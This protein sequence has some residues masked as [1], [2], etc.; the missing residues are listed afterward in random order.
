VRKTIAYDLTRTFVG[1]VFATPRGVD[2]VDF[3]FARHLSQEPQRP[4]IGVLPTPWGMRV[5][6]ADRVERGLERLEDLWAETIDPADDVAYQ[7]LLGSLASR[8]SA[9]PSTPREA[10]GFIQK[11]RRM[12]SLIASTGFSFGRS[13]IA[14][15]PRN[16]V[17]FNVGQYTTAIPQLLSWLDR[18]RD[19]KPVFMLHDVIPLEKPECVSP[20]EL[21]F[22]KIMVRS[23]ARY[24]AGLIVTT[25]HA[26]KTILKA[27]ADEGRSGI[28]TLSISLPL[29]DAF[30]SAAKP[31][32]LLED[33]PYFVVCG[34]VEPRKNHQLLVDVW[35][36]LCQS[37]ESA[38]HL[39]VIGSPG[40]GGQPILDRMFG[41]GPT[42]GKIHH[43]AGLSTPAM[44]SL[45]AGS[46]GLLSPSLTEGFGLPIIEA[47]HLGAPVVAS[48]IPAHR[49]VAGDRATLVDP[50]D[51]AAWR[52]AVI[53]LSSGHGR[54]ASRPAAEASRER[55]ACLDE[56]SEFLQSF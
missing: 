19:V 31:E 34:A 12:A 27:L 32:P 4:F 7:T 53:R 46:L 47:L 29:A 49:E 54:R 17:Y 40:W 43:V 25:A 20:S 3:L 2:R 15:I 8:R 16:S 13:A 38:P 45:I 1:P 6:E 55:L 21:R 18:R 50:S 10:R 41:S 26:R 56:I 33:V 14:S 23:I 48:D 28:R 37:S 42:L 52:D 36:T 51:S 9:G 30:D 35:R 22:H 11:A 39:V 44:K 24:G 5:Y